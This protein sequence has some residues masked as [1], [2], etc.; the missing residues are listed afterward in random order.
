MAKTQAPSTSNYKHV[1]SPEEPGPSTP[2]APRE[3]L[4]SKPSTPV[5]MS[6]GAYSGTISLADGTLPAARSHSHAHHT[7]SY[8]PS[9]TQ[10]PPCPTLI[11]LHRSLSQRSPDYSPRIPSKDLSGGLPKPRPSPT[12][13]PP[14]QLTPIRMERLYSPPRIHSYRISMHILLQL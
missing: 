2:T 3:H 9:T 13:L 1:A 12:A 8:H 6:K 10:E 4:L 11:R 14:R 7:K 5:A